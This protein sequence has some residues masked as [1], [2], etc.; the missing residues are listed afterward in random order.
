MP[1][2]GTIAAWWNSIS[3]CMFGQGWHFT[4]WTPVT[5]AIVRANATTTTLN[6]Q[7]PLAIMVAKVQLF[8][9]VR[10][11][12][13]AIQRSPRTSLPQ[14]LP[15]GCVAIT[16][17]QGVCF[18]MSGMCPKPSGADTFHAVGAFQQDNLLRGLIDCWQT[19]DAFVWA[20]HAINGRRHILPWQPCSGLLSETFKCF[21]WCL[22]LRR[23]TLR[24]FCYQ[25]LSK[26][27]PL[28]HRKRFT[29]PR[30][31]GLFSLQQFENV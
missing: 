17:N 15:A 22:S 16:R 14:G 11:G 7:R 23:V 13:G 8:K 30:E 9:N 28:S 12:V 6:A 26:L 1:P 4:C 5:P 24:G 2:P 3:H 29:V 10:A 25:Q 18:S 31:R 21:I 27:P 20:K 19:P